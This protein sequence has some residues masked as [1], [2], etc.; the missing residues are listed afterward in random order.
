MWFTQ[1]AVQCR[2]ES[3]AP[4]GERGD[5]WVIRGCHIE[6]MNIMFKK[7]HQLSLAQLF[8]T[9]NPIPVILHSSFMFNGHKQTLW[10]RNTQDSCLNTRYRHWKNLS[11]SMQDEQTCYCQIRLV[12]N[13]SIPLTYRHAPRFLVFPQLQTYGGGKKKKKHCGPLARPKQWWCNVN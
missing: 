7:K 11:D 4:S 10:W 6:F 12:T 5:M 8:Q 2:D 13:W 3:N 1:S 9:Q